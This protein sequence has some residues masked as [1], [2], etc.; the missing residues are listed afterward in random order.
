MPAI[1]KNAAE[2]RVIFFDNF[3]FRFSFESD[4]VASWFKDV[5][6]WKLKANS[7]D[8]AGAMNRFFI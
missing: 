8:Q 4:R 2:I 5:K 6:S 1:R 7:A 3:G